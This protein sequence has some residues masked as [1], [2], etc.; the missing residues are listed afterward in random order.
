M[1]QCNKCKKYKEESEFHKDKHCK[2]GLYSICKQCKSAYMKNRWKN[3]P[4][5][6]EKRKKYN[7]SEERRK[8]YRDYMKE[9]RKDPEYKK[10]QKEYMKQYW[11]K[12]NAYEYHKKL[13]ADDPEQAKRVKEKAKEYWHS[14]KGKD[15]FRKHNKKRRATDVY[16]QWRNEYEKTKRASDPAYNLMISMRNRI[17]K[18]IQGRRDKTTKELIGCSA[19][20]LMLH[21][22]KQ[23]NNGMNWNNYGSYWHIDHI[24]P[25]NYFNL[26]NSSECFI[27][28]NYR[29]LQPMLAKENCS[30]RDTAPSN[31]Q[32][33]IR[34][35]KD[36]LIT[37]GV[38]FEN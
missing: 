26:Q 35:I 25:C 13:L 9:K 15:V 3:D 32:K 5:Y 21:I 29:N 18:L 19:E 38:L 23:F 16:K 24:V 17:S 6:R 14:E 30:K 27:A 31:A 33:I 11:Q 36:A 20:C 34:K 4:E 37:E 2:D 28:F 8:Y 10:Q 7:S 1:K 22:E 12:Y